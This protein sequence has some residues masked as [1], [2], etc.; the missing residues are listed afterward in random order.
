MGEIAA[1]GLCRLDSVGKRHQQRAGFRGQFQP[2][3]FQFT[4]FRIHK[5]GRFQNVAQ[6]CREACQRSHNLPPARAFTDY[7]I[8]LENR[9]EMDPD[10]RP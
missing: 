4:G 1:G 3:R 5:Q 8:T 2:S 6:P 7:K 9:I 10:E